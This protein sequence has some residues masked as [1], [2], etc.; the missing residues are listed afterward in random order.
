MRHFTLFS[1]AVFETHVHFTTGPSS[2]ACKTV[3]TTSERAPDNPFWSKK[4][5]QPTFY[6]KA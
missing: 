5:Q 6:F 1:Y 2:T 3:F 4:T